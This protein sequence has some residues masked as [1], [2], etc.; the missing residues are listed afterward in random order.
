MYP[1]KHKNISWLLLFVWMVGFSVLPA[2]SETQHFEFTDNTGSNANVFAPTDANPTV[3]GEQLQ[4]GDE[5][6]VFTVDGLC[7]G[8]S[9]WD[10]TNINITIWGNN[11]QTEEKDGMAHDD[12]LY[13]RVWQQST[14]TEFKNIRVEY[15]TDS[16]LW[17]ATG[18][19]VENAIYILDALTTFP[20]PAAPVLISPEDGA[21]EQSTDIEFQWN[22]SQLADNYNLQVANTSDFSDPIVNEEGIS[23][24][25]YEVENLE[26]QSTY[27]WRVSG[28]NLAGQG[29]WSETWQFATLDRFIRFMNPSQPTV[30][31][32]NSIQTISWQKRGVDLLRI[33][34]S[35]NSGSDWEIIADSLNAETGSYEWTVPSTPSTQ[36]RLRII[37]IDNVNMVALSP[38]FSIYP[39]RISIEH[40]LDFGDPS[41][42]ASYRMVG[43]PGDNNISLS[44][45]MSGTEGTDWI[46]F[47]D[48]GSE[49]DYLIEYD[50]S[51]A[52]NFRPG[53]GFW[54]LSRN[55]ISYESE[56]NAVDLN[57]ENT[58]AI[59][60]HDGWN[61]ISNPFGV[62]VA[63]EAV[64]AQNEVS[65]PIW[66]FR[67]SFSQ[68][69]HLEPN[70]GYYFNNTGGLESLVI[71]YP[72]GSSVSK[73]TPD[74]PATA[75]QLH[76]SIKNE[77]T[78][79]SDIVIG[80][81]EEYTENIEHY[82]VYAPPSDFEMASI[83][84]HDGRVHTEYKNPSDDGY[85][86]DF[87]VSL[88]KNKTFKLQT[89]GIESFQGKQIKLINKISGKSIDLYENNYLPISSGTGKTEYRLII[90]SEDFVQDQGSSLL[91][92]DITLSQN[93][94]NPFNPKTVIE[95]S[96]PG[97][98]DNTFVTLEIFNTLG[99]RVRMLVE[100]YQSAGF[101]SV[102]W[103]ARNDNGRAVPSGL[104]IY[105]LQAGTTVL[106]NRMI[107][108]Q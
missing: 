92:A 25:S 93:Y 53:R 79:F 81:A 67:G 68:H 2:A 73:R 102:D 6:G 50:G 61:I 75:Q 35:I 41:S 84:M 8:A 63:W 60:L 14:D 82:T 43:L 94:P 45:I 62:P 7:V 49:E 32:E 104:Y 18:R 54:I 5:I 19:Y 64:Q 36:A 59:P 76:I 13:F 83:R 69:D 58:F 11:D 98:K 30:W 29:D 97:D 16:E 74:H 88:P 17:N 56:S 37:D 22:E 66:A 15:N 4:P 33:E 20:E 71:P 9:V 52:F 1:I 51:T 101:Y 31:V 42:V 40:F 89:E 105:R 44:S 108:L 48:D 100:E 72:D 107:Y 95:Y 103:D 38:A 34:Y 91:P 106:S 12:S 27:Y 23:S 96:L 28:S 24:T 90:G 87:T 47:R 78:S 65:Q 46:A 77:E 10:G 39:R 21:G 26:Y 85:T 86:V 55:G 99:Q 3:D 70:E 80:I 57:S